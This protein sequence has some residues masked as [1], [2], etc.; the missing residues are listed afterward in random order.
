MIVK[1]I[2]TKI[3][4]LLVTLKYST[5]LL[6]NCSIPY[7]LFFGLSN[8]LPIYPKQMSIYEQHLGHNILLFGDTRHYKLV[9]YN[10]Y[11][12]YRNIPYRNY[13]ESVRCRYSNFSV[14]YPVLK[15]N[16]LYRSVRYCYTFLVFR[17]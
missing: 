10:V 5:L 7:K 4:K 16:R 8:N 15:E 2:P 14:Q 11:F 9:F 12:Y 17:V 3:K 13:P 6:Y 1:Q